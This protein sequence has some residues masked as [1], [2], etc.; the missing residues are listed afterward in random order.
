V[1]RGT[2]LGLAT[3][4]GIVRQNDGVIEVDS[5]PGKGTEFRIYLPRHAGEVTEIGTRAPSEIPM[6]RGETILL[7]EDERA[8]LELGKSL[9]EVL[10]YSVL[11]A[12]TPDEAIA[13]VEEHGERI[14]LLLTDVVMPGMNGKELADRLCNDRPG[15]KCLYMS[16]YTADVIAKRGVLDQQVA[17]IQKPFLMRDLATKLRKVLDS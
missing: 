16:G 1:G 11:A 10:G 2:G 12:G 7:V 15:M 5:E 17:F 6:G 9:L 3:V 13:W 14:D 4:Y 8:I